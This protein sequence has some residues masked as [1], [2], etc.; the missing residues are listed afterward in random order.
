[1]FRVALAAVLAAAGTQAH[2]VW[3]EASSKHFVIYADE[4]PRELTDFATKLERFD[5]VV[6][7]L[8]GM[9]DP[10]VGIGNR[11]TV[12]VLPSIEA[13]QKV[14]NDNNPL[15]GGFY[16][17]RASGSVAYVPRTLG[18]MAAGGLDPQTIFFHEYSHHLMAQTVDKP[19]PQWV[20]EG[21]AEF[22]SN[23][24]FNRNGD[25][26]VGLPDSSRARTLYRGEKLPLETMLSANYTRLTSG[27]VSSLYARAW[28]LAHYLAFDKSRSGQIES[29][30][31]L[32]SKGVPP[33]DAARTAFG[34][35]KQLDHELNAYLMR[36]RFPALTLNGA[37]FQ[38]GKIDVQPLSE[39]ASQVIML[40]AWSKSDVNRTTAEPLAEKVRAVEV[41]YPGDELV[42]R[43]LAEAEL[44]AGHPDASEGAADRALRVN[45]QS[46]EAMIY[47]GRAIALRAEKLQG[48]ARHAAFEQ[49]RH[50][51]VTANKLDTED[52]QSLM[53][54]YRTFPMEGIKPNENAI[55]ALHY[56]SD[57][58]PQD[59]ILRINSAAR[60]LAD[61]KLKEAR[62]AL[63]PVA[64]DPHEQA[65]A[66]VAR[67][68]IEK[69][70]A[71]D[72]AA[73]TA[74]SGAPTTESSEQ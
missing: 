30:V 14:K 8:R 47:K 50:L 51:F 24:E 9:R 45:P 37:R 68:M 66:K 65:L 54:F 59:R 22:M 61:G 34:D 20:A 48:P 69:I 13:V 38:A 32:I 67:A 25:I 1:L 27:Q 19:H 31:D 60:Y 33:L 5:Q 4:S 11:L 36:D 16:K 2:A 55:A 35:L 29:Y 39:G 73:A 28:L 40:R 6:R 42:E 72:V 7:Y 71:G 52:P 44:D 3:Y 41:R 15:V 57:L 26:A 63:A 23:V 46:T 58:A 18:F 10:E 56:A 53:M 62:W 64:Y 17:G 43:T 12:F 21:F 49:A 70:N 74:A